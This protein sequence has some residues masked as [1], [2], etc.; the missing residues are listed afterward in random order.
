LVDL[1]IMDE[2]GDSLLPGESGEVVVRGACVM[3]GYEGSGGGGKEFFN[4]D[5][6]RTGD[7]GFL[8]ADGYLFLT[9]RLKEIIN[10]GGEKISPRAVDDALM[11]HPAVEEAVAFPVP[12]EVLGEEVA[13]AVVLRAQHG[14][15]EKELRQFVSERL[16]DFKV[17]RQ[18][19]I[20]TEIPKGSFGKIERRRLAE[21]LDVK[22]CDQ[23][24]SKSEVPYTPPGTT[25][26]SKLVE[27]WARVLG[28]K[29]VGVHDDFFQLGGDSILATQV[30]AQVR[31]VMQVDLSP[32]S[33]FETPTVAELARSLSMSQ[34][35]YVD[36]AIRPIKRI[37]RT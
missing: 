6:F 36:A 25:E 5:W 29:W 1:A 27:I 23:V 7:Q 21:L 35:K 33:L 15:N 3:A 14:A 11:D 37:P 34:E 13:A 24:P 30:A 19:L 20:L 26:E 4:G 12:N 2:G 17:P 32:A 10:R 22:P 8:D 16:T 28:L 18:I 9:G 31:N